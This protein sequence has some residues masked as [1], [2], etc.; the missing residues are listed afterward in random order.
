MGEGGRRRR[1]SE[2]EGGEE[3]R[4]VRERGREVGEGWKKEGVWCG[5]GRGEREREERERE[6]RG[7]EERG[8]GHG[9]RWTNERE[10]D[11]CPRD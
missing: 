4:E 11:G 5:G 7:R 3:R 8:R 10:R 6:E 2:R 1:R 9:I